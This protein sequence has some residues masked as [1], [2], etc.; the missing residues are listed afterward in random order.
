MDNQATL[1]SDLLPAAMPPQ[2]RRIGIALLRGALCA[3]LMLGAA[4]GWGLMHGKSYSPGSAAGYALGVTGGSLMLMLLLYPLRKRLR[5]MHN[6]GPLKHWFKLH[7]VG[8]ILG[9]VLVLLHS[10][11]HVGSLNAAVALSCMLL[12]VTSGIVGRFLYRKIHHGLYG[13]QATLK[14]LHGALQNELK[15]LDQQ[16]RE[17]PLIKSEID[18][19]AALAAQAPATLL[20]RAAQFLALG[21]MRRGVRRR[22]RR[23]LATLSAGSGTAA[24]SPEKLAALRNAVDAVLRAAQR[25]AQFN[26]N[27]RLFSLWHVVHIPF[28]FMMVITAII[29][30]VAVHVY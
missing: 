23:E 8:G 17:M 4:A 11:F 9:P 26:T 24:S 20:Q 10:G 14:Q 15:S 16:L 6:W 27:E 21:P 5:F 2:L 29:H 7:M 3:L 1:R 25:S 28:L 22:V 18:R 30:V 12:V 19:F 13:S